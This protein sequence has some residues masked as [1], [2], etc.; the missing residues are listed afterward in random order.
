[1]GLAPYGQPISYNAIRK[2]LIDVKGD[3]SYRL[4]TEYFGYL[5]S[6][7]MTND[8]FSD[9]FGGSPRKPETRI[10]RREMDLAASIQKVLEEVV[11]QMAHHAKKET[12]ADNL[13][14]AGGVA[15][16]CVAN[17]KILKERVFD[18]IWI[19]PAAGDAGG[20]LGAA[21]LVSHAYFKNPRKMNPRGRDTQKGSYL[22]PAYS[23]TEV[24]AF[25]GRNNHPYEQISEPKQRARRIAHAI[26]DGK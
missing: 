24:L 6:L 14:M 26:A 16:N 5:D 1:M 13:V 17:G 23:P 10:T 7:V 12:G 20:A 11:L 22:G 8:K 21:L 19:Q 18:N 2:N 25:L 4:N 9:L 15:L 3:V